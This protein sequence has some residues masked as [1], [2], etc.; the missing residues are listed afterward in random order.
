MNLKANSEIRI[1][2]VQNKIA[3]WQLAVQ[4][5][6]HESTV[7]LHLRAELSENEKKK[8]MSAIDKIVE[9]RQ[10]EEAKNER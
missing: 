1:K 8:Y 6:C 7:I 10:K 9:I 4:L 3:I 5:N 2:M